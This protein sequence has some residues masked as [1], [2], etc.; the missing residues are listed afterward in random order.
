MEFD[1]TSK[2][3]KTTGLDKSEVNYFP[4]DFSLSRARTIKEKKVL[5]V[6]LAGLRPRKIAVA[7]PCN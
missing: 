7:M 6:S 5:L 2:N 3:M 1:Y 4:A